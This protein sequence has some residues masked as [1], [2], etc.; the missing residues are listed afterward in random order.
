[1][2]DSSGA[3]RYSSSATFLV[4][5]STPEG[6]VPYEING[7]AGYQ[8]GSTYTLSAGDHTIELPSSYTSLISNTTY[9]F[10]YW[11]DSSTDNPR[12]VTLLADQNLS[13]HGIYSMSTGETPPPP[14][15]NGGYLGYTGFETGASGSGHSYVIFCHQCG[16]TPG[17]ATS[18]T[19]AYD[20]GSIQFSDGVVKPVAGNYMLEFGHDH[21]GHWSRTVA[22]HSNSWAPTYSGAETYISKWFYFP[23]NFDLAPRG[24]IEFFLL[25]MRGGNIPTSSEPGNDGHNLCGILYQKSPWG[26]DDFY[27]DFSYSYNPGTQ[28]IPGGFKAQVYPDGSY[29]TSW[30]DAGVI[31][32]NPNPWLPLGRWFRLEIYI[33]RHLTDGVWK[34]WITDPYNPDP[35]MRSTILM[36]SIEGTRTTTSGSSYTTDFAIPKWYGYGVDYAYELPKV[37]YCDESYVYNYNPHEEY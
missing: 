28:Y 17:W 16:V 29:T 11:Q 25:R 9:Y 12:T 35:S 15:P 32:T 22:V 6:S 33:Y 27:W 21:Y 5:D 31:E 36:F 26:S 2:I 23:S 14:P 20:P 24:W 30:H 1:M 3:I 8:T 4:T 37:L 19:S 10:L 34:V 13:L 7:D 18:V